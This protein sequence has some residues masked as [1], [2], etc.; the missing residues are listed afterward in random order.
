M[1]S[2]NSKNTPRCFTARHVVVDIETSGLFPQRG[3]RIVEIGAVAI[4]QGKVVEE[5]TSLVNC[6]VKMPKHVQ[7]IHGVTDNMLQRQPSPE[8]VFPRFL[9]FVSGKILIAHNAGFDIKFLRYELARLGKNITNKYLC[10]M[11]ISRK[12]FPELPD[13]KLETVARHLLGELPESLRLHRALDDARL[14]AM[15]WMEMVKNE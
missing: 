2:N 12:R 7:G 1:A 14:T 10:T 3:A 4:E 6:G 15:V 8:E 9:A 5:F 13:H 11:R